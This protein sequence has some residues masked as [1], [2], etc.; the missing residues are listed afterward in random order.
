MIIL[1]SFYLWTWFPNWKTQKTNFYNPKI[2]GYKTKV[3]VAESEK[4]MLENFI[5]N[6]K[7]HD[8]D[9][10][11]AWFGLKFDLPVLLKRLCANDI[12]PNELSP[13]NSVDGIKRVRD[14][15]EYSKGMTDFLLSLSPSKGE[16]R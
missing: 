13:V 11:I 7:G 1:K 9:M 6:L 4:Q 8:P 3:L 2:E 14:G 5:S 10:L 12:N 15:W 16:S